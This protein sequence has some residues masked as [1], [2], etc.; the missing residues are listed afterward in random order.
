[1][2][3]KALTCAVGVLMLIGCFFVVKALHSSEYK[4]L[5]WVLGIVFIL[6]GYGLARTQGNL[7]ACTL[8]TST[9]VLGRGTAY[10]GC[11]LCL[12]GIVEICLKRG[13]SMLL[14]SVGIILIGLLIKCSSEYALNRLSPDQQPRQEA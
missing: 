2:K 8:F 12:P 4:K 11:F 6:A 13:S 10:L 7:T 9:S 1:M 5:C 14:C 3:Q